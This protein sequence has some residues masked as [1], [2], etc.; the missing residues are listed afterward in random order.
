MKWLGISLIYCGFFALIGGAI[1]ITGSAYPLFGLF[2][3]P[4][5]STKE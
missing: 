1:Y 3:F 2:F 4:L 5:V